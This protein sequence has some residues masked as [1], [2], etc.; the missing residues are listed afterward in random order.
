VIYDHQKQLNLIRGLVRTEIPQKSGGSFE[1]IM[2]N[3]IDHPGTAA[4]QKYRRRLQAALNVYATFFKQE[5]FQAEKEY[6]IV[7]KNPDK[8]RILFREKDG[9]LLPYIQVDLGKKQLLPVKSITVAPKNHVDLARKGMR[10]YVELLGYDIPVDLSNLK[11]R[12]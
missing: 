1:T 3:E 8:S 2:Q 12:Y 11:L 7:F 10:Q 4:F 9:F 5:E 6:R